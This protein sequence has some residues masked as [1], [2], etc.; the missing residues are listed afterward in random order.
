MLELRRKESVSNHE[1]LV[2][3]TTSA[4]H[5]M[6]RR[7]L[8]CSSR[9]LGRGHGRWL[10]S[11]LLSAVFH[12]AR[13]TFADRVQEKVEDN[14]PRNLTTACADSEDENCH[15]HSGGLGQSADMSFLEEQA[16]RWTHGRASFQT[17]PSALGHLDSRNPL[18]GQRVGDPH[19]QNL[20]L[21]TKGGMVTISGATI[22][23]EQLIECFRQPP[24]ESY[25]SVES[26]GRQVVGASIMSDR[27][28][29]RQIEK[30][31][32]Y[33]VLGMLACAQRFGGEEE[34]LD[35]ADSWIE[36]IL[37]L[38]RH[39]SSKELATKICSDTFKRILVGGVSE[40]TKDV[41]EHL[42][43]ERIKVPEFER[44]TWMRKLPY[45]QK[46]VKALTRALAKDG[47]AYATCERYGIVLP[48]PVTEGEMM[49]FVKAV[50]DAWER[51]AMQ[52]LDK[53]YAFFEKHHQISLD[54]VK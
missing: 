14:V 15:N 28:A 9:P 6:G 38:K 16:S 50:N 13:T 48:N 44:V 3:N 23:G 34:T 51:D 30:G 40:V 53:I 10:T 27:V 25:F 42:S 47:Q 49:Q 37:D 32:N 4:K 52:N 36:S 26:P 12:V 11:W 22:E 20:D 17:S 35:V 39:A 33:F 45:L 21:G 5:E 18:A 54:K 7:S 2:S 41:F 1:E 43:N 31:R 29:K 8:R 46:F 24:F 19:F